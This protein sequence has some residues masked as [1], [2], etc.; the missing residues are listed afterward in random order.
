MAETPQC[1]KAAC[2][3]VRKKGRVRVCVCGV[4]EREGGGEGQEKGE[5]EEIQGTNST[6]ESHAPSELLPPARPH[7]L[8][9]PSQ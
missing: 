6:V 8:F 9:R 3:M 5:G 2:L 4:R 1:N 7:F